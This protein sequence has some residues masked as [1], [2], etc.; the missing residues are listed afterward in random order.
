MSLAGKIADDFK[1]A[2]KGGNKNTVAVL[3]MI[4]S[5]MK[6]REI[7]KRAPLTDEDVQAE[8]LSFAKRS[9]ESIEQFSR[10]GRPDLV[11]K[12]EMEL[13]VV[14][15][16]LP[17]Q[18]SEEEVRKIINDVIREEGASGVK[19]LGK[20]MKASMARLKGQAEGKMI[21]TIVK[22]ILEA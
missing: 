8:L 10:A 6:N 21:S 12:E 17:A 13:S 7:E 3:R 15:S 16:Y 11:E 9:K 22:E 5:S 14:R 19:E 20:V 18:L 4:R 2:L 1:Q